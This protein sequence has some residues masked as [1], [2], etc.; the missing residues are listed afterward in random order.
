MWLTAH[1]AFL[2]EEAAVGRGTKCVFLF[3]FFNFILLFFKVCVF[4][5]FNKMSWLMLWTVLV[6]SA[7]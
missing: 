6:H 5:D 4:K 2:L 7:Q 1:F 3:L